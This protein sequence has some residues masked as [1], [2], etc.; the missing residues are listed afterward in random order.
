[1]L[2]LLDGRFSETG[3]MLACSPYLRALPRL[4][5]S[6]DQ[7]TPSPARGYTLRHPSR[8]TQRCTAVAAAGALGLAECP[9]HAAALLRLFDRFQSLY[10]LDRLNVRQ[11]QLVRKQS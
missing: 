4:S 5:L 7:A 11:Q 9:V 2:V 3:R 6:A 1:M 10:T 8:T